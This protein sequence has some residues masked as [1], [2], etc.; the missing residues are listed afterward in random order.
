MF[1]IASSIEAVGV[2]TTSP[3]GCQL[4]A[5]GLGEYWEDRAEGGGDVLRKSNSAGPGADQALRVVFVATSW[6][7]LRQFVPVTPFECGFSSIECFEKV[8]VIRLLIGTGLSWAAGIALSPLQRDRHFSNSDSRTI[9][10][11]CWIDN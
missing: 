8:I 5:R 2:V 1:E 9:E 11:R 6:Q 7:L 3:G 10:N 4:L